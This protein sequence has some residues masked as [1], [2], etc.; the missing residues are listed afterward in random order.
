M[1]LQ[2]NMSDIVK[3]LGHR[4]VYHIGRRIWSGGGGE[5]DFSWYSTVFKKIL[6]F[7]KLY[8]RLFDD[9]VWETVMQFFLDFVAVITTND[10]Q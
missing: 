6:E 8:C 1:F 3:T 10:K 2:Q 7:I 5:P 9:T 4:K